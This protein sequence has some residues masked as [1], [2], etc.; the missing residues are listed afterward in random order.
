MPGIRTNIGVKTNIGLGGSGQSWQS[1]WNTLI[2]AE[3]EDAAPTHVV[4]TCSKANNKFVASDFTIAGFTVLSGSWAGSVYTLVLSTSVVYSNSL[5]VVWKGTMS[6]AVI[7]N[8]FPE[9][10]LTTY[11]NGL[12]TP[13]SDL[14][15]IKINDLIR[16]IK[17]GLSITNLSDAFDCIWLLA[18]ET[19]ESSYRNLVKNANHITDV[20]A[21]TWTAFEGIQGDGTSQYART[22]Y[23]PLTHGVRFAANNCSFGVYSR[24]HDPISHRYKFGGYGVSSDTNLQLNTINTTNQHIEGAINDYASY[25][26]AIPK[27]GNAGLTIVSRTASNSFTIHPYY[28]RDDARGNISSGVNIEVELLILTYDYFGV[29]QNFSDDQLSL[30]FVGRA[31]NYREQGVIGDAITEYMY[32]NGKEPFGK[33]TIGSNLLFNGDFINS[34]IWENGDIWSFVYGDWTIS[35]GVAHRGPLSAVIRQEIPYRIGK[36]Y[37]L[38]FT[39]SNCPTIAV[40]SFF[41]NGGCYWDEFPAGTHGRYTN[42][43]HIVYLTCNDDIDR[44]FEIET[45][46]SSVCDVFDLSNVSLVRLD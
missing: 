36:H 7:N 24:K 33:N 40:L 37:K 17:T 20:V 15:K 46:P 22:N 45:Y 4:L 44:W 2:S 35:G 18:G 6:H 30:I 14:T 3:V 21:P 27:L 23:I 10:E 41:A 9:T 12:A 16:K 13:L 25:N 42:G 26:F 1:Y 8:V 32:S 28:Y 39:I 34:E 11:I 31:F 43:T 38:E 29:K 19:K 5:T